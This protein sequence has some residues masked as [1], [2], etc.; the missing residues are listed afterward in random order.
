MPAKYCCQTPKQHRKASSCASSCQSVSIQV[1]NCMHCVGGRPLHLLPAMLCV[2]GG[3]VGA[4]GG[5][6]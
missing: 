1:V 3:H 6:S 2:V 5:G 4:G